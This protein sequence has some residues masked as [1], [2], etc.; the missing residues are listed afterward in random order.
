MGKVA[1]YIFLPMISL[2]MG[3]YESAYGGHF[4][5]RYCKQAGF[6]CI[7]V[8]AGDSW[9]KL[10]PDA[11]Q[12]DVVKRVNRMN[13]QLR[14]GM[15]IAVPNNLSYTDHMDVAPFPQ[16][17]AP[18]GSKLV[19]VDP[20]VLAWGAYN[21]KGELL[22]WGPASGGKSYCSDVK[23]GC[24]TVRGSYAFYHKRGQ[25]C[26]SKKYP[27]GRGGAPMP[28]CMFFYKGFALHGSPVVPGYHASHGC[29]RLFKEDARWLN[30]EFIELPS[31]NTR[32]TKIIINN[33]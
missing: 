21:P 19:V 17:I 6:H 28:Y 12:R 9:K 5:E 20:Q 14:K 3:I 8:K 4:G 29:V 13:T 1:R 18:P 30:K 33:Y 23:R 27:L 22:H 25:A 11:E 32:G 2:T 31:Y 10:F 15:R 16:L 7:K 24:R 26:R